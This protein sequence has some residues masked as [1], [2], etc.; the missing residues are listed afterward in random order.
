LL[1]KR[2]GQ[3]NF[4]DTELFA[5]MIPRDHPL[6]L[7][8]EH[9]SFDFIEAATAELYDPDRGRP[10]VPPETL[11]RVLFLEV[12]AGLS[13]VQVCQQLKYNVLYRWFCGIG[14]DQSVPDDTTLVVFRKRLGPAKFKELFDR[15]LGLPYPG[16]GVGG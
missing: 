1:G 10:S 16:E 13:D 12:W 2:T 15:D 4:F 6:A 11:F 5:K 14:W 3:T 9:V 8:N 7:I